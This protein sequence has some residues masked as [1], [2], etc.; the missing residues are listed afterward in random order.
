MPMLLLLNQ[1]PLV[2]SGL[3]ERRRYAPLVL[4]VTACLALSAASGALQRAGAGGA[5]SP[6]VME[7][8]Q[9][10]G[11]WLLTKNLVLLALAAPIHVLF[12]RVR[13]RG[14]RQICMHVHM[15]FIP[16]NLGV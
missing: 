13:L 6:F 3:T 7:Q 5:R 11:T 4:A 10:S 15:L 16:A 12:L 14:P 1:D 9:A 8:R 2:F